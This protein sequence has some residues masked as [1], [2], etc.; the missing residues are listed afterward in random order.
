MKDL[1]KEIAVA[2][3][4]YPDEVRVVEIKGSQSDVI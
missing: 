2:L 4:D 1:A 3:V